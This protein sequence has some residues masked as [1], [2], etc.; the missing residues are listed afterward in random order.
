MIFARSG[1]S[2]RN[3]AILGCMHIRNLVNFVTRGNRFLWKY[4]L[5]HARLFSLQVPICFPATPCVSYFAVIL[6][7]GLF[8]KVL[9]PSLRWIRACHRDRQLLTMYHAIQQP[10][11]IAFKYTVFAIGISYIIPIIKCILLLFYNIFVFT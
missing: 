7:N 9:L 5:A 10:F 8:C 4:F 11:L 3:F 6:P 1:L 2:F